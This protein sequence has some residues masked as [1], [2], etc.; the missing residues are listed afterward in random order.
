[1]VDFT[2]THGGYRSD[3]GFYYTG[4]VSI[5]DSQLR[6]WPQAEGLGALCLHQ[7]ADHRSHEPRLGEPGQ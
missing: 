5:N 2:F 4:T 3:G 6:W 7:H 1:V